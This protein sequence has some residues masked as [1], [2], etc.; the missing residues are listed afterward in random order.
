MPHTLLYVNYTAIKVDFLK[1]YKRE[2]DILLFTKWNRM[3]IS[4]VTAGSFPESV[5]LD[6]K[7]EIIT[8]PTL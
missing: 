8:V 3:V 4:Y 2:E 1:K 5:F 6:C 7:L